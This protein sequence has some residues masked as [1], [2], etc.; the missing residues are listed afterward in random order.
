METRTVDGVTFIF[1]LALDSEA[2]S[3]MLI[4]LPQSHVLDVAEDATHTLHNLLPLRGSVVRD[5]N[6]WSQYLNT[7]LEQFGPDVQVMIDQHQWPVWG[8]ERVRAQLAN[9]RDLY[10]Y[11][12]DHTIRMMNQGLGPTEIAEVVAG[13]F[14]FAAGHSAIASPTRSSAT[15]GKTW[16]LTHVVCRPE[17]TV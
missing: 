15:F 4:Y 6:R 10:K 9:K 11:I 12:H 17:L 2:P 1:Q 16:R 3:E 8:N 14:A 13:D 7:A 5:A